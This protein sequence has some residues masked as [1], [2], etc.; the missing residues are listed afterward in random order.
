KRRCQ[1]GNIYELLTRAERVSY[2]A[3]SLT[4]QLI[5]F[6]KGGQPIKKLTNINDLLYEAVQFS[7]SGSSM[8]SEFDLHAGLW[9]AEV[10]EGQ[11][12][13]V[14]TNI[15]INA[16][17]ACGLNGLITVKTENICVDK[18]NERFVKAGNYVKITMRDNGGGIPAQNLKKIFDPYF[19]TKSDGRGIGLAAAHSIIKNH[20]GIIDVESKSGE[21]TAF[22]IYLPAGVSQADQQA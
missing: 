4:E 11:L 16:R 1:D 22:F 3:K 13:Q 20:Q 9:S 21:G 12:I 2:K 15:T 6:S 14:I 19:T 8:R 17:Q 5:T 7:L 18:P 10:D